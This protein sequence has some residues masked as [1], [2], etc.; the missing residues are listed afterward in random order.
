LSSAAPFNLIPSKA[1]V[2]KRSRESAADHPD[3]VG[4]RA[5]DAW[6][7]LTLNQPVPANERKDEE[8][9]GNE[10]YTRHVKNAADR[11]QS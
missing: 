3:D 8:G 1:N 7:N 10:A 2:T 9:E 5:Q 11:L 6:E 4:D